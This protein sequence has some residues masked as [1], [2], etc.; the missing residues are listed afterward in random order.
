MGKLTEAGFDLL[1]GLKNRCVVR[2]FSLF[3]IEIAWSATSPPV[4]SSKRDVATFTYCRKTV[5]DFFHEFSSSNN[6][7][8][9]DP[10]CPRD[11]GT[12]CTTPIGLV[13]VSFFMIITNFWGDSWLRG[14]FH[15]IL[16][17]SRE[18]E[19]KRM[20]L[21]TQEIRKNPEGLAFDQE[22]DLLKELQSVIQKFLI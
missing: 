20:N 14:S 13:T 10:L 6:A 2:S 19:D 22:L 12:L 18:I 17:V 5:S 16:V 11:G 15:D 1:K 3:Q 4:A 21:F 9:S 7:L 8:A